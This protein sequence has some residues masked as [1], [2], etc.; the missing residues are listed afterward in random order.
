MYWKFSEDREGGARPVLPY[1]SISRVSSN[2][3]RGRN[4][5]LEVEYGEYPQTIVSEDFARTLESA[6]LNRTINQTGKSYTTDSVS[7]EDT[8]IP[9]QAR[10]HIEY[11][12]NGRKYIRFV[13]DRCISF[14]PSRLLNAKTHRA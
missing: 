5:I 1:S 4:G 7:Y 9:F 2:G 13:A 8:D 14:K 10:T 11:E 12:Y 3:V 6:Y